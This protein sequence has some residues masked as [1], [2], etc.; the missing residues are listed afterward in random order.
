MTLALSRVRRRVRERFGE[1][2]EP[3]RPSPL[4]EGRDGVGAVNWT[5]NRVTAWSLSLVGLALVGSLVVLVLLFPTGSL[6]SR[7]WR[8]VAWAVTVVL[9]QGI[10]TAA[11]GGPNFSSNVDFIPNPL[12][13]HPSAVLLGLVRVGGAVVAFAIVGAI[14]HLAARFRRSR[15]EE[16]EQLKW[17]LSASVF[18]PL[19]I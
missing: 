19:V 5:A 8:P 1:R 3:A 17:F 18:A 7:R 16:R 15:G 10:G 14:A 12:A 13:I 9:V 4:R 2:T 11:F 6:I